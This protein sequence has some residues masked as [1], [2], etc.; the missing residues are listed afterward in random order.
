MRGILVRSFWR[1]D[2]ILYAPPRYRR[3]CR[4]DAFVPD[5]LGTVALAIPSEFA[6]LIADAEAAVGRLNAKAV[7]ALVPLAAANLT[8]EE[9]ETKRPSS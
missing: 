2:P 4:Y 5:H 3:A 7:P 9:L 8:P 6:A 1:H